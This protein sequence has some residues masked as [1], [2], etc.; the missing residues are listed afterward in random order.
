[1]SKGSNPDVRWRCMSSE[2][3]LDLLSTS[4]ESASLDVFS[5]TGAESLAC[6]TSWQK[7]DLHA[8]TDHGL[9]EVGRDLCKDG[10][11]VVVGNGLNDRSCSLGGVTGEDY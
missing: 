11:V 1:M 9:S 5:L 4:G 6:H 7:I 2:I 10:R 8:D 3:R